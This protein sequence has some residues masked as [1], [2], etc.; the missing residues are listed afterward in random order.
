M[1]KDIYKDR[2]TTEEIIEGLQET[3]N[4]PNYNLQTQPR[5]SLAEFAFL[6]DLIFKKE[7]NTILISALDYISDKK[8]LGFGFS[9]TASFR[10]VLFFQHFLGNMGNATKAAIASGYSP[11]SAKQQ[12]HRVLKWIQKAQ[13]TI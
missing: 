2:F 6:R 7:K 13:Y 3:R 9:N 11:N 8:L 10:R 1:K 4:D 12:G 5:F